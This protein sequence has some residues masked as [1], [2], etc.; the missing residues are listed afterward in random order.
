SPWFMPAI[1]A[2]IIVIGGAA[3]IAAYHRLVASDSSTADDE[4][5]LERFCLTVAGDYG[6]AVESIR[7]PES[8][9]IDPSLVDTTA[10]LFYSGF[11]SD[12]PERFADSARQLEDGVDKA[13]EGSLT[14]EEE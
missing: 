7:D 3:S 2:L 10:A 8:V 9:D 4:D 1:V 11:G 12:A 6:V 13:I 14:R 5:A